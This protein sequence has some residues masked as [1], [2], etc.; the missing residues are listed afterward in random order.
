MSDGSVIFSVNANT[1]P[2]Q[3]KLNKLRE[4]IESME[5]E[6]EG[7]KGERSALA[8][9]LNAAKLAAKETE[10]SVKKL[11]QEIERL[12]DR[13]WIQKQGF[14]AGEYQ[15]II[16]RRKTLAAEL[17]GQEAALKAQNKEVQALNAEY[18]KTV[19]SIEAA[20]E[21][22]GKMNRDAGELVI[23]TAQEKLELRQANSALA[24]AQK[25]ASRFLNQIKSLARSVLVFSLI[26]A[27]LT[28]LRKQMSAA[29][30]G[31]AEAS[32]AVAKLK[33]AL[34]TLAGPLMQTVLPA[35][36]ELVNI[37]AAIVT[38]ILTVISILGGSSVQSMKEV[39]E[40]LYQESDALDE[41]G[42]AAKKAAKA[43]ASFDEINKLNAETVNGGAS[44]I[45]PDFNFDEN[46][47]LKKL[48]RVFQKVNEIFKTIRAGLEIVI[49]DL[50]WSFDNKVIPQSKATWLTAL[51]ALFGA[52]F[53]AAFGGFNGTVIG[54][55]L[56]A[57]LGLYLVELSPET[58]RQNMDGVTALVS[59]LTALL[60]ATLG[61]VFG[62]FSGA[63]IGL[64]LGALLGLYLVEL[65]PETWKQ[66][67]DVETA[68]ITVVTAL[69]G[70]ALGGVFGKFVGGMI[71][72]SLGAILG[73][74]ISGFAENDTTHGGKKQLLS[75]LIVVLCALLGAI[76]GSVVSPGVGTVVGLG[77]GLL[78]G[79]SIYAVREDP[80]KSPTQRLASMGRS[81]LLGLIAGVLGVGLAALGIVSAG[82]AFVIAA[83]IGLA[84]KFFIDSVD[85]SAIDNAVSNVAKGRNGRT[86]STSRTTSRTSM[87]QSASSVPVYNDIPAL[88]RGAVI[89]PNREFLAVLGDQKSGTNIETPLPTMIQAFKQALAE[90]GYGGRNEAVL[91]L[92]RDV[93][94]RVVYKLNKAESNRVGVSLTGM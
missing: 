25:Y 87:F 51:T 62:G 29:I 79:L 34:L 38:E 48:D 78:L 61:A 30:R 85:S 73:L 42:R 17:S 10:K 57:L 27:A 75:E 88:A 39:S 19:N 55:S 68:L 35:L 9:K 58:W 49:D 18:D 90:S 16:A 26:S 13:E 1:T 44:P 50:K 76:I 54:L 72:L 15:Q 59:A 8:A 53:G 65:D 4:N 86:G 71:G 52:T 77:V 60:G 92:D 63:V 93:L 84:L 91:V 24:Q 45:T 20:T 33:G 28:G 64:S 66:N 74:Y 36:T 69:L 23:Q 67:L 3:K 32:A 5:R 82:T 83:S 80:E 14:S 56:G 43:L 11:R 2:A 81:V 6:L 40:G 94:G 70:A 41:T 31:N 22:L 47:M 89:P 46:P 21:K 37:L 7:K 12:N